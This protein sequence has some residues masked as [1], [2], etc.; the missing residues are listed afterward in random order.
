MDLANFWF[1][2]TVFALKGCGFPVLM[3]REK[4]LGT[5]LDELIKSLVFGF[6]YYDFSK[7]TSVSECGNE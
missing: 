3:N 1:G 2:L 4:V 7:D 5:R 6:F